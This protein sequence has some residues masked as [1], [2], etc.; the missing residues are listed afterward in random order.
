MIVPYVQNHMIL[1]YDVY[2]FT[3]PFV[4]AF[5]RRCL[6]S[7]NSAAAPRRRRHRQRSA[8]QCLVLGGEAESI[9]APQLAQLGGVFVEQRAQTVQKFDKKGRNG[10]GAAGRRRN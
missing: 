5:G 8:V 2:L 3:Q 4:G 6:S 9:G 10:L 1:P 7:H